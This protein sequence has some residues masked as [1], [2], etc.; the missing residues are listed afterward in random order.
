MIDIR[1]RS[2]EETLLACE[3]L[4]GV[5]LIVTSPP[6]PDARPGQYGG[7]A[8]HDFTW[9]DYQRLGD[10]VARALKPGC[11]LLLHD[12]D[13]WAP[14]RLRAHTAAAVPDICAAARDKGLALTTLDEL[15]A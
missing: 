9:T 15:L 13:G 4:G 11:I 10:H 12:A 2:F 3:A 8:S 14:D 1:H 5:D 7:D 6:Y